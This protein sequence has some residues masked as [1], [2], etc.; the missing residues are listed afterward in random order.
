MEV[1]FLG[2]KK[3]KNFIFFF[4]LNLFF[5][6]IFI[7]IFFISISFFLK[8]SFQQLLRARLPKLATHFA[9]IG[10][11]SPMYATQW[12]ITL[13]G[14]CLPTHV[15]ARIWD[16][17]LVK[18]WRTVHQVGLVLLK[19]NEDMFLAMDFDN[20]LHSLML[21]GKTVSN[22]DALMAKLEGVKVTSKDLKRLAKEF[23]K[24]GIDNIE[25]IQQ[26][27]NIKA[28]SGSGSGS[29]GSSG[30]RIAKIRNRVKQKVKR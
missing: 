5:F 12:F 10:I 14:S 17:F 24:V 18:K 11:S 8:F 16:V 3:K 30:S 4:F 22:A 23:S 20:A 29:S 6:Y 2:K 27:M 28:G 19:E 1:N 13:Y 21:I 15:V 26:Q 7:F 9:E 25:Q